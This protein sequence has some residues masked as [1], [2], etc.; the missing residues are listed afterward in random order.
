MDAVAYA[1]RSFNCGADDEY[2]DGNLDAVRALFAP[3]LDIFF[4][5]R[6]RHGLGKIKCFINYKDERCD[7]YIGIP[8][9]TEVSNCH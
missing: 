4:I 6:A 9:S 8:Q 2:G 1:A 3:T 7:E 5:G